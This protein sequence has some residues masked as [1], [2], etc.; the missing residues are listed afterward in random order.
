MSKVAT[1]LLRAGRILQWR[2]TKSIEW[3]IWKELQWWKLK[4]LDCLIL[5][6]HNY[7][8]PGW[9][10]AYGRESNFL[11]F[12]VCEKCLDRQIVTENEV[13]SYLIERSRLKGKARGYASWYPFKR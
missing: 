10:Y 7:I 12:K 5:A 2:S 11:L 9:D 3:V 8:W 6:K 1:L 4:H 13:R